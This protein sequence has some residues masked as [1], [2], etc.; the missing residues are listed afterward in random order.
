MEING[1]KLWDIT[2][3]TVDPRGHLFHR[4][5]YFNTKNRFK[6]RKIR[7]Y[8]PSTYDF[9]NPNKR[10]PVLYMLDGKNLFDDY[11]SFVGEWLMDEI[12][13]DAI[14]KKAS[15]G[16]I[17]V[18]I[19]A[20]NDAQDRALEMTPE[21]FI[22]SKV[23]AVETKKNEGYAKVLG[24]FI[25]DKVKPLIDETFYTLKDKRHTGVGGSSMGGLMAFYLALDYKDY[26]GYSMAY[27]PAFFLYKWN[28]FFSYIEKRIINDN[29]LPIIELYVGGKGFEGAF[30]DATFKVFGYFKSLGFSDKQIRLI[31]QKEEEHN[32]QAWRKYV[33]DTLKYFNYLK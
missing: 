2:P 17:V 25:F 31:Y 4:D 27:S 13:E 5:L 7:V 12:V 10:F 26:I 30:T 32:E 15:E 28:N 19:D 29:S 33:P 14:E 6:N 8:L 20:P 1:F 9:E 3:N 21:Q 22:F 18:G 16:I 24:D 23:R 11:T